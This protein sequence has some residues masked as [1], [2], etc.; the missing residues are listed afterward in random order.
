MDWCAE[1]ALFSIAMQMIVRF[2]ARFLCLGMTLILFGAVAGASSPHDRQ[3]WREISKHSYAVPEGESAPRL[4]YELSGLLASP[5]PELRDDLA[6]TILAHWIRANRLSPVE[7]NSLTDEWRGN[8]KSHVGESGN[9]SVLKRS[10]SA[11]CLSE[12]AAHDLKAPFLG[13]ERY[14]GLLND[15]LAY[16]NQERDL[17]GYDAKL[18]WIH[19]TAH[20]ADLLRALA[21]NPL[22]TRAD[23][24]G[25]LRAISERLSTARS[26][27]THG[28]QD[29]LA[30]AV[31]AIIA[32]AD[33][34]ADALQAWI[35][36]MQDTDN[37]MWSH[38]PILL[39]EMARYQN[40]TYMLEALAARLGPANAA[41]ESAARAR[42]VVFAAVRER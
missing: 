40:D 2:P 39:D 25:I 22:L 38:T 17:R 26:I 36:Q 21:E 14:R 16:L 11:L 19:A 42:E 41:T 34:D 30:L 4:A 8:L 6:Y 9:D 3:F 37:A 32:R 23:Q 24:P 18:G 1:P 5:D 33:F 7:L 10:F 12:T 20:T 13:A 31:A 29:R 15:A 28:E 35:K 27:Y